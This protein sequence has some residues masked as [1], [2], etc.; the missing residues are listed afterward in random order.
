MNG[1]IELTTVTLSGLA[2]VLLVAT[3]RVVKHVRHSSD[4]PR[5]HRQ[6]T[7]QWLTQ[8]EQCLDQESIVIAELD[9]HV[10]R[11]VRHR[12]GRQPMRRPDR[13]TRTV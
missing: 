10:Q 8:F 7:N 11:A 5:T 9:R 2:V 4:G 3:Y 13:G 1:V 6:Q 12:T